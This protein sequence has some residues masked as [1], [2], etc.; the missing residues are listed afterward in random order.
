MTFQWTDELAAQCPPFRGE[1]APIKSKKIDARKLLAPVETSLA[2]ER[3]P[4]YRPRASLV[5]LAQSGEGSFA[6]EADAAVILG[7]TGQKGHYKG[8]ITLVSEGETR[9]VVEPCVDRWVQKYGAA[10][11][12]EIYS[13]VG[14]WKPYPIM[15]PPGITLAIARAR[16]RAHLAHAADYDAALARAQA[17]AKDGFALA[18]SPGYDGTAEVLTYLFPDHRP[19]FTE[20]VAE[21][22][23]RDWVSTRLVASVTSAAELR[24]IKAIG[25]NDLTHNAIVI[26]RS[27]REAGLPVLV[28]LA[29]EREHANEGIA[30]ALT[31][32]VSPAAADALALSL[33]A[34]APA[35]IATAYFAAHPELKAAALTPLVG[36]PKKA[37][38]DAAAQLLG[39]A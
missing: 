7:S 38:R 21:I 15:S 18:K 1:G 2:P 12:V 37:V 30:L 16:L 36:H 23:R 27:L 26:A 13:L 4:D 35:K 29:A 14:A 33:G 6:D 25:D 9:K 39:A 5:K 28:A 31:A 8:T 34:K 17:L 22:A 32:Y 20:A 3:A 10:G 11:A 24:S 19:F